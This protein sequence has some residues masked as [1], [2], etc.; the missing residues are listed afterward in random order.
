MFFSFI[1]NRFRRLI[2]QIRLNPFFYGHIYSKQFTVSGLMNMNKKYFWAI[3]F[4][5]TPISFILLFLGMYYLFGSRLVLSNILILVVL[6]NIFGIISSTLYMLSFKTMCSFFLIGLLVG[7]FEMFRT[8]LFVK[9]GWEDLTGII[10]LLTWAAIG[11]S[12]GGIIQFIQHIFNAIS[13]NKKNQ[14]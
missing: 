3:F 10:L 6:S 1:N 13:V 9:S 11:L 5:V 2:L 4:T 7:F 12:V 8:F 14:L